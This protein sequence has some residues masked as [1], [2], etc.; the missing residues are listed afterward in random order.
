[1]RF[2]FVNLLSFPDVEDILIKYSWMDI[3][4]AQ[5]TGT[6]VS[7][8]GGSAVIPRPTWSLSTELVV[9]PE[10][11]RIWLKTQNILFDI[12]SRQRMS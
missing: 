4:P 3:D 11:C 1:M 12:E 8:V 9:A 5:C 6:Q 7:Y 2:T 10:H